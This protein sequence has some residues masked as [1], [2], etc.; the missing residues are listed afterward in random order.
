MP[1]VPFQPQAQNASQAQAIAPPGGTYLMM[2]AAQMHSEG[3]LVQ[4]DSGR[5][6]WDS[7][8]PSLSDT[9]DKSEPPGEDKTD[10]IMQKLEINRG[11]AKL[12]YKV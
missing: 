11:M 5:Q 4:A 3:R 7:Q 9:F 1:V 10:S 8:Q 6:E 2:A 12:G